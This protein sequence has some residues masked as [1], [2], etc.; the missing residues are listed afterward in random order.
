[1]VLRCNSRMAI[2]TNSQGSIQL[3]RSL[4]YDFIS[5]CISFSLINF[6]I[7][8]NH[9]S[10][11]IYHLIFFC[12]LSTIPF[13]K[14]CWKPKQSNALQANIDL[15]HHGSFVFNILLVG[16]S[17]FDGI[18]RIIQPPIWQTVN[19]MHLEFVSWVFC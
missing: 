18:K 9:D 8:Y 7:R 11:Y 10:D 5:L 13:D 16:I 3:R 19:Q 14:F 1:M 4:F 12:A 6:I 15:F 2:F 17:N